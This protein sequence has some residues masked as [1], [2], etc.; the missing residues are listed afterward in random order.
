VRFNLDPKQDEAGKCGLRLNEM[1][2]TQQGFVNPI[3]PL[4]HEHKHPCLCIIYRTRQ[5]DD[6]IVISYFEEGSPVEILV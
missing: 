5:T 1:R 4:L 6:D 3:P 2:R